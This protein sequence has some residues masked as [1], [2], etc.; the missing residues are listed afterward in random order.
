MI[1]HDISEPFEPDATRAR[2][3]DLNLRTRMA[4]SLE[5]VAGESRGILALDE[6]K[7]R[8]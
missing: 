3:L 1:G 7:F 4:E 6:A 2:A 8:F 5:Y